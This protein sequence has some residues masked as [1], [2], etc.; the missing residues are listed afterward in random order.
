MLVLAG[1]PDRIGFPDRGEIHPAL[2]RAR[3]GQPDRHVS[4]YVIIGT[5][6]SYAWAIALGYA[7]RDPAGAGLSGRVTPR[8]GRGQVL[9][10]S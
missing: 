4:E 3:R 5:L 6:A 9:S 2:Q 10:G 7:A 1:Q 8:N